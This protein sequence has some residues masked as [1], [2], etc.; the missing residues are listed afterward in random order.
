MAD[1]MSK[2]ISKTPLQNA[3]PFIY[4]ISHFAPSA[5]LMALV[6][7]LYSRLPFY[8]NFLSYLASY[9]IF[10]GGAL[11]IVVGFIYSVWAA[12]YDPPRLEKRLAGD[13]FWPWIVELPSRLVS[14]AG[15]L[16]K[17]RRVRSLPPIFESEDEKRTILGIFVK[18]FFFPLMLQFFVTNVRRAIMT[19][20]SFHGFSWEILPVTRGGF[21]FWM[22]LLLILD[23]GIFM[24]AYITEH[25]RLGNQLKS[26][27]STFGGWFVALICYPPF[28]AYFTGRLDQYAVAAVGGPGV[29]IVSSLGLGDSTV[30]AT[31]RA[32][33]FLLFAIYVWASVALGWRAGNLV[34]RGIVGRGPY[35]FIRHPAYVTKNIGWWFERLPQLT[36]SAALALLVLNAIYVL[37]ALTEEHHLRKDPDYHAYCKK[38]R[39]R[40]IPGLI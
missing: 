31:S 26:V 29:P 25:R 38:V 40:F 2:N 32:V 18:A 27:D 13:Y 4:G 11:Y 37:R 30:L 1:R 15:V 33:A 3:R 20:Q 22:S 8:D 6:L 5:S 28:S 35:R 10:A 24:F 19:S 36:L 21:V 9:I 7:L 12:Y 17:E 34:N 16:L 39:W 14:G 23:T